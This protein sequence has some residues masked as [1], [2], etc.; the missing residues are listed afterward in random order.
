MLGNLKKILSLV[1]YTSRQC[2]SFSD[3]HLQWSNFVQNL[4]G[5]SPLCAEIEIKLSI[6]FFQINFSNLPT[7]VLTVGRGVFTIESRTA[8]A[9]L[10]EAVL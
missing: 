4:H 2:A 7:G 6:A 10:V 8:R 5:Y 1:R 3:A 9:L